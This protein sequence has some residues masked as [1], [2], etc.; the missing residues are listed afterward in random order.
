MIS[1]N[2]AS[3]GLRL[4]SFLI[5]ILFW[6]FIF[7]LL[8]LAI[9]SSGDLAILLDSMLYSLILWLVLATFGIVLINC[10]LISTFGGTIGKLATGTRIVDEKEGKY[11]SFYYAFLRNYIGY[12]VSSM[13]FWLGFIWILID[14]KKQGWHD[15]LI[16]SV[17]IV[18][19]KGAYVMAIISLIVVMSVN[20]CVASKIYSN[21]LENKSVYI[22]I[23]EDIRLEYEKNL[24]DLDIP[25]S[26]FEAN[27]I[28]ALH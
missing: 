12:I 3:S 23:Y 5:D 22:Q 24:E 1:K 8:L 4:I 10:I 20:M 14:D 27:E 26:D 7:Q 16:G 17:V 25:E 28:G 21:F 13:L 2:I 19:T 11:L 6:I 9:S 15:M 18:R